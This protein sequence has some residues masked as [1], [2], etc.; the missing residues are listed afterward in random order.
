LI[1]L[2]Y[3]DI[4]LKNF[5]FYERQVRTLKPNETTTVTMIFTFD[6]TLY[7]KKDTYFVI[8]TQ[9]LIK[10]DKANYTKQYNDEKFEGIVF[11]VS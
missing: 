10:F 1:Y 2:N 6:A 7:D 3:R 4:S 11:K 8:G 5:D 9:S